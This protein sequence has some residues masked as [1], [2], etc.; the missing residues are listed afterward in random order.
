MKSIRLAFG[1][2]FFMALLAATA[3]A[4]AVRTFVASTGSDTNSCSRATPCRTFQAAVDAVSAGGEVVALDS[5]GF[6]ANLTIDKSVS[7]IASPGV[8]AGIVVVTGHGVDINAGVSDTV[9]LRGL[10]ISSQGG[11][12]GVV[13]TTGGTLRVESCVVTGFSQHGGIVFI[14]SGSLEVQDSLISGNAFG[15]AVEAASASATLERVRFEGNFDALLVGD[16]AKATVRNSTASHNTDAFQAF[17]RSSASSDL[18][19][20]NCLAASNSGSGVLVG[21]SSTGFATVRVS[22]STLTDNGTGLKNLGGSDNGRIL[23]RGN[24]TVE[25]NGTDTSGT[26]GSYSAK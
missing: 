15:I 24:N 14:G 1:S 16:G 7:I 19:I 23:S 5:A 12:D 17:S 13:Y 2:L 11:N 25:G 8:F 9:V 21:T 3:A 18:N 10:T 26:I 6:G 22:N 20:E 4:Q